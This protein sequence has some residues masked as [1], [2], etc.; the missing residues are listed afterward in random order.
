MSL[1]GT[2]VALRQQVSEN[3]NDI[4]MTQMPFLGMIR[5][6]DRFDA[7]Q[8]GEVEGIRFTT[9]GPLS[10]EALQ[11]DF[12]V[13]KPNARFI[14]A[15]DPNFNN[16]INPLRRGMNIRSGTLIPTAY[17]VSEVVPKYYVNRLQNSLKSV[18]NYVM[19]TA[20]ATTDALLELWNNALFPPTNLQQTI[21]AS[22]TTGAPAID[23][24]MAVAF[25]LQSGY[26]NNAAT[27]TG[28]Y[29]YLGIDMNL[30]AND[31]MKSRQAGTVAAPFGTPSTD[32]LRVEMVQTNNQG[33]S[34]DLYV[35]DT[36]T[37]SFLG[38]VIDDYVRL[39]NGEKLSFG[40]TVFNL[41]GMAMLHEPRLDRLSDSFSDEDNAVA[42][43]EYRESYMLTSEVHKFR[44]T[45]PED[46]D[47][48]SYPTAPAF[49]LMEGY[50]EIVYWNE[51]PRHNSRQFQL[52]GV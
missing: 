28:T 47:L 22:P 20:R 48:D 40:G 49:E 9:G 15:L 46:M 14:N 44:L 13:G 11:I 35:C 24:L 41:L 52:T 38:D 42:A 36:E 27:G 19:K 30:A 43:T 33:G 7:A 45:T 51:N 37:F 23:N 16:L 3:L 21:A 18:E 5:G 12:R 6:F 50:G 39:Q 25:P 26:A 4:T 8:Y 10:G 32:N 2:Q 31:G 1:E 29:S 17:D 34:V